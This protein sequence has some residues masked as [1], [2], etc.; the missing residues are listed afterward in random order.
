VPSPLVCIVLMTIVA[1]VMGLDIRTVGDMGELPDTLP[2]FLWPNVPLN[3]ETLMIIFP[4]A[5]ML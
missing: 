5:V 3:L 1:M 2:V 4:Y